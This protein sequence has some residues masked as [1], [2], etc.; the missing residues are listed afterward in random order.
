MERRRSVEKPIRTVGADSK[1]RFDVRPLFLWASRTGIHPYFSVVGFTSNR[2]FYFFRFLVFLEIP[3]PPERGTRFGERLGAFSLPP[4]R[5]S[6]LLS[7]IENFLEMGQRSGP[8]PIM[9][10]EN[11]GGAQNARK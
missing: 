2:E 1:G 7:K 9:H 10:H 4:S 8:G 5:M 11:G 6:I 3:K